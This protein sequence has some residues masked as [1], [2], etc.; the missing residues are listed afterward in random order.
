MNIQLIL[1]AVIGV[2]VLALVGTIYIEHNTIQLQAANIATL[3]TQNSV[4]EAS[5]ASWKKLTDV[6]NSAIDKLKAIATQKA[7]D[8]AKAAAS[9]AEHRRK[10]DARANALMQRKVDKDD[11]KGAAQV[12]DSYIAGRANQ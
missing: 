2:I 1:H 6:Q 12:L 5:N 7:A 11:C 10:L 8:A 9:V 3:T 4:C